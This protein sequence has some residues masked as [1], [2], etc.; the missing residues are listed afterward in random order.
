MVAYGYKKILSILAILA[1]IG[2]VTVPLSTAVAEAPTLEKMVF[3]DYVA[4][5]HLGKSNDACGDGSG[6][7]TV[8]SGGLKWKSFPVTYNIAAPSAAAKS[9]VV[10]AFNEWDDEEHPSGALFSELASSSADIN[11]FWSPIDGAGNI[12]AQTTFWYNPFTKEITRAEIAFDSGD[13]WFVAT[14]QSCTAVGSD[15][16]IQNV[17]THEIGHALGLGHANHA[18]L[19]MYRY[20]SPGETLKSSLGYGDQRGLDRLY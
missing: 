20:A 6:K 19:T 1:L 15:F 4:P 12:L 16:D 11:V 7:Y 18:A 17:A 14:S 2:S 3:V 13:R 5:S 8:F 9:A 10:A